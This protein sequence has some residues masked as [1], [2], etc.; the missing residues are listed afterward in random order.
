[1]GGII[2][3]VTS[4]KMLT[5][6]DRNMLLRNSASRGSQQGIKVTPNRMPRITNDFLFDLHTPWG[7]RQ[8]T[9]CTV[10]SYL[11]AQR[12]FGTRHYMVVKGQKVLSPA[13]I[14]CN[15]FSIGFL[16]P[17]GRLSHIQDAYIQQIPFL[18]LQMDNAYSPGRTLELTNFIT[19]K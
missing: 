19:W 17:Q 4:I 11:V 5:F 10:D 2:I 3:S 15:T 14:T 9:Q 7:S 1:M 8:V 18:I 6:P 12:H 13:H 16:Q